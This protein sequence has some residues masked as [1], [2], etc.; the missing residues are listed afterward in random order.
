MNDE[1]YFTIVS[2]T[3]EFKTIG[4]LSVEDITLAM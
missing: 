1:M 4:D 3:Q 2:Q